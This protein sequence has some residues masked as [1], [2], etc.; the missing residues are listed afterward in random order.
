VSIQRNP[1]P[2]FWCRK[3]VSWWKNVV[4]QIRLSRRNLNN[5]TRMFAP[6]LQIFWGKEHLVKN[7]LIC[8]LDKVIF[9]GSAYKTSFHFTK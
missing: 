2:H 4:S 8:T 3:K 9:Q 1:W 5:R 6:D 7:R